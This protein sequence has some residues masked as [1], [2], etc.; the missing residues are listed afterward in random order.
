MDDKIQVFF[1]ISIHLQEMIAAAERAKTLCRPLL[2][3]VRAAIEIRKVK[4]SSLAMRF[5]SVLAS[6]W[7]I[8]SDDFI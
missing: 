2:V 3:D 6:A 8:F 4:I 1:L 7:D 5:F